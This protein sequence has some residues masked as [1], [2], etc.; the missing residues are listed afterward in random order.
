MLA[1]R[2]YIHRSG[3]N[4]TY[5]S[6]A[7]AVRD[8]YNFGDDNVSSLSEKLEALIRIFIDNGCA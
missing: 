6:L 7:Q 2:G 1:N 4:I 5:E 8:V 3:R